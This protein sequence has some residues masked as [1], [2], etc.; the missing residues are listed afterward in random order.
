MAIPRL[1]QLRRDKLLFTLALNT[2]RLHLEEADRLALAPHLHEAPDAD[3]QLIQQHL[4]RWV[5]TSTTYVMQKYRCSVKEALEL[6][7]E[8]QND[9]K[10]GISPS[11]LRQ[12]PLQGLLHVPPEALAG[13]Q[14]PAAAD[15]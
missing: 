5:S 15:Q 10:R 4:D 9:L 3:L 7:G 6:I 8:L 12:V 1:R 11:E 13:E 2:V 14:P